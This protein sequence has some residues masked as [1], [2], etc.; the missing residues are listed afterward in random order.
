MP[1]SF[2][3]ADNIVDD[4]NNDYELNSKL[5]NLKICLI[6]QDSNN[7]N[8]SNIS[9]SSEEDNH[10]NASTLSNNSLSLVNINDESPYSTIT[11]TYTN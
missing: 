10:S 8:N 1:Y 11:D 5:L 3:A 6:D 9:D 2:D 4:S 7:S